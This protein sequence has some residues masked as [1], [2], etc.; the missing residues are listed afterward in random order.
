LNG[1]KVSENF[2]EFDKK[3]I[4]TMILIFLFSN[5]KEIAYLKFYENIKDDGKVILTPQRMQFQK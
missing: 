5:Y 2:P 3:L 1:F 4:W